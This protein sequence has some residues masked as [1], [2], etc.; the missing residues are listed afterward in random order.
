M[1]KYQHVSIG[2]GAILMLAALSSYAETAAPKPANSGPCALLKPGDLTALLGS[3]PVA[4]P[5]GVSCTWTVSGSPKMLI[6]AHSPA[7]GMSAEMTYYDAE[8]KASKGGPVITLRD[9]G[10]RGFARLNKKGVLLITIKHGNLFQFVYL[11][12]AAGTEK[13]LEALKPVAIKAFAAF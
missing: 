9:V 12:G 3:T 13:D 6:A 10:D 11:T 1:M 5:K 7:T 8:K 2:F 4:D